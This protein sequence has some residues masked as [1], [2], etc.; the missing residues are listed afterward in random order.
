MVRIHQGAYTKAR[1]AEGSWLCRE[2]SFRVV[3]LPAVVEPIALMPKRRHRGR[4]D[5]NSKAAVEGLPPPVSWAGMV[6]ERYRGGVAAD[7]GAWPSAA[8]GQVWIRD[9]E[10]FAE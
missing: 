1:Q 3:D 2:P 7:A 6:G 9:V 8:R 10:R 4:P 5:R